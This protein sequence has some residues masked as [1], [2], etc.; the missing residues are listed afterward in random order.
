MVAAPSRST[1]NSR[2]LQGPKFQYTVS[3]SAPPLSITWRCMLA[4]GSKSDWKLITGGKL[5]RGMNWETV[6]LKAPRSSWQ[7]TMMVAWASPWSS[8]V[9]VMVVS[10]PVVVSHGAGTP[11]AVRM[12]TKY[13]V[14]QPSLSVP[15]QWKVRR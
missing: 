4:R 6:S 10:V 11:A 3:G 13:R 15:D 14:T 9:K 5:R 8:V 1:A 12:D 7:A 2:K